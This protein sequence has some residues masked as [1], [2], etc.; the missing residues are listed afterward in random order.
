MIKQAESREISLDFIDPDPGQP[1]QNKP[2]DYLRELGNSIKEK[3]LRNAIHVR[4]NPEIPGRYLIINGECRWTASCLVGLKTIRADIYEY[5]GENIQGEV[6]VDQLMDNGVRKGLDP[7]EELKGYQKAINEHG[8]SISDIAKAYGK[9]ADLI[10]KDLPILRLP[11][12][13]LDLYDKGAVPK[14]VARR[15]AELPNEG[16]MLKAW[17]W[18]CNGKN[19]DG[20]LKKIEAYVV[21]SSQGTLDIFDQAADTATSEEKK[22]AKVAADKL[23]RAVGDFA[24]T[25]FANGKGELM[26]VVNSRKLTEIEYT[27][28]EMAKIAAKILND[29]KSYKARSKHA[30][31]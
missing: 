21:N 11:K 9:S 7:L 4:P 6:F 25:P 17:E 27:A 12:P 8:M 3:G 26:L 18:A 22:Q 24:K 10:E 30:A 16:R 13:L 5:E 2:I 1:R 29:I 28:S 31:A 23:V 19:A 15:L 20:M 14:Q